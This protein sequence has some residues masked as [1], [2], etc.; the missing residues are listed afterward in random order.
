MPSN[1]MMTIGEAVRRL[2]A[3]GAEIVINPPGPGYAGV[4]LTPETA[5]FALADRDAFLAQ[6]FEMTMDD[7][8]VFV[9][10]LG[11]SRC[12]AS[13]RDG[14]RCKG[15]AKAANA[16][17]IREWRAEDHRCSAHRGHPEHPNV[18]ARG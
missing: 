4:E 5:P 13:T 11:E 9:Q 1:E 12:L 10:E 16:V 18:R 15:Y 14:S 7:Y 2:Q 6:H 3:I 8:E 17:T